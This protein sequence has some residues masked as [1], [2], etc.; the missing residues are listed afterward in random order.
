MAR[1]LILE[2]DPVFAAVIE[3]RLL[4]AGHEAT[5]VTEPAVAVTAATEGQA[6][7]LVLE[8]ELPGTSGLE[9]IRQLRQQSETRSLPIVALSSNDDSGHRIAT[10]RAGVDEFLVKPCDPEE[11][12]L[13]MERFLGSREAAPQVMR[14]D[15]ASHRIWELLQYVQQGNKSGELKIHGKRGSGQ[16]HLDRGY[17][18]SARWQTLRGEDA[19]LAVAD[20]KE[21]R[22][23]L[24][25]EESESVAPSTDDALRIQDVLIQAAWIEDQLGQ[26]RQHVPATSAHLVRTAVALPEIEEPL[27][28]L[29]ILPVLERIAKGGARL[30]DLM[31]ESTVAPSRVRLTV[32]WLAE[33]GLIAPAEEAAEQRAMSTA[34]ISSSVVFDVAIHGLLSSARDAGFDVSALPYLLLA[35]PGTW[36][37]LQ[38]LPA[39]VPGFLSHEAL[40]RLVERTQQGHGGSATFKTDVGKLS[41]HVQPLGGAK[42]VV[43]AIVPVCAGVLVWLDD[44]S[45]KELIRRV[46]NRLE[47]AKGPA[48]GILV[49]PG[50]TAEAA[51]ELIEGRAKWKVSTHPPRSLLGVLRLLHPKA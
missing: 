32:A 23:Q 35:E 16:V 37:E 21:G 26:R 44:A 48:V 22:F 43:E 17:V 42:Q 4:V 9:I 50:A 33:K 15:L 28:S 7:V 3:D 31:T 30:Y 46:V 41:L 38:Q 8:M 18:S 13:R 36:P 24:T 10:L 19:L 5:L 34:E 29:P 12:M 2:L 25:T 1:V 11:L 40:R 47:S 20:M 45:E 6:D 39:S 51:S 14:G 27:R 49:A